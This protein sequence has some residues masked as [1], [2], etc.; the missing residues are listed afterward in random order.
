MNAPAADAS[1]EAG[2]AEPHEP[3]EVSRRA[4]GIVAEFAPWVGGDRPRDPAHPRAP[5]DVPASLAHGHTPPLLFVRCLRATPQR[6]IAFRSP[7]GDNTYRRKSERLTP[8]TAEVRTA[9]APDFR[10]GSETR[11]DTPGRTLA[12]ESPNG[13]RLGLPAGR[14]GL[15][16]A[17]HGLGSRSGRSAGSVSCRRK[18]LC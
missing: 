14:A 12:A 13:L 17:T 18:A 8:L 3:H 7:A 6:R 10:R 16:P 15:E 11:R 2:G 1:V 5:A 9:Y 4:K